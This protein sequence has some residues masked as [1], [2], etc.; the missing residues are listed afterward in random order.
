VVPDD[1]ERPR[2]G[3]VDRR[4]VPAVR[5][6]RGERCDVV[7]RLEVVAEG[8][9]PALRV[10]PDGRRDGRE[11]RVACDEHPVAVEAQVPVGVSGRREHAPAV[12]LVTR[13]DE[14]RIRD[15]LHEIGEDV[16]G[17]DHLPRTFRWHPVTQEPLGDAL[18]PVVGA[19]DALALRVVEAPLEH[20]RSRRACGGLGTADVVGV[21]VGD[22]DPDDGPVDLGEDVLPG[23]LHQPETGVHE[24]PA[25]LAAQEV[26]MDVHRPARQRQ[27]E[28]QDPRLD[29]DGFGERM[30]DR[31]RHGDERR[32]SLRAVP[33]RTVLRPGDRPGDLAAR[34]TVP[35][36]SHVRGLARACGRYLYSGPGP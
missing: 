25:V 31:M 17:L 35:L 11:D 20:G 27:G 22:E 12:D 13:V 29:L 7:E 2:G 18:R 4:A 9:G 32:V 19:P 3:L 16:A 26:A 23:R 1:H 14:R 28:P 5:H 21:H 33:L 36:K 6:A 8:I 24:R 34:Q 30:F 10:E 15:E